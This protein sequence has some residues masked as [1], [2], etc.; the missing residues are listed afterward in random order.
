MDD[1]I[2]GKVMVAGLVFL[3]I[4]GI[5]ALLEAKGEGARRIKLVLGAMLVLGLAA[6]IVGVAGLGGLLLVAIVIGV[7]TWIVR[8]F[9]R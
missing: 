2:F 7:G 9:R 1:F 5:G 8:G 3:V 4:V 6:F